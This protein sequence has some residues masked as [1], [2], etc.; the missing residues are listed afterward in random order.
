M[1][2]LLWLLGGM[3]ILIERPWAALAPAALFGLL[4]ARVR[5]RWVA[6]SAILWLLYACYEFGMRQRWLCSGECNIRIDLLLIYPLLI[7]VS[8]AALVAGIRAMRKPLS[9]LDP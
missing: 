8:L 3:A 7:I 9:R 1:E 6:G 2:P 5:V 4:H